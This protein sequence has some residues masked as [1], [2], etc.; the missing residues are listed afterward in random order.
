MKM[1]RRNFNG[2]LISASLFSMYP[3]FLNSANFRNA[4]MTNVSL[5]NADLGA[6]DLTNANLESAKIQ[7]S[8]FKNAKMENMNINEA[9]TDSCFEQDLINRII[10]KIK[11]ELNPNSPPYEQTYE[12]RDNYV[13]RD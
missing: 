9:I 12:F 11:L 1:N 8:F 2:F 5:N 6:A 13:L 3:N 4:D 7:N 10:C